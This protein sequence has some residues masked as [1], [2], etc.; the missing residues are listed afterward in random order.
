MN[1]Q[2]FLEWQ[3]EHYTQRLAEETRPEAKAWLRA[4]LHRLK[5]KRD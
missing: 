3:I 5:Q 2:L 4:E 1:R